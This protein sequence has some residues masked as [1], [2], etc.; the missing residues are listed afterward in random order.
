MQ[1]IL[2]LGFILILLYQTLS[3]TCRLKNT[4]YNLLT[5]VSGET[6]HLPLNE[7]FIGDALQYTITPKGQPFVQRRQQIGQ[8]VLQGTIISSTS[9]NFNNNPYIQ[10]IN[11]YAL[12][13]IS[14]LDFAIVQ[15]QLQSESYNIS[16]ASITSGTCYQVN[17]LQDMVVVTCS[18]SG[19]NI[20]EYQ[21]YQASNSSQ[22]FSILIDTIIIT[23]GSNLSVITQTAGQYI[24]TIVNQ[25]TFQNNS[26]SVISTNISAI[27]LLQEENGKYDFTQLQLPAI[28]ETNNNLVTDFYTGISLNQ[29]GMLFVSTYYNGFKPVNLLDL[30]V[31]INPFNPFNIGTMGVS[32][33]KIDISDDTF[34]LSIWSTE[35]LIVGVFQESVVNQKTGIFDNK[36]QFQQSQLILTSQITYGQIFT[37]QV[38]MNSRY[39]IVSNSNGISV[40]PS[41]LNTINDWKVLFYYNLNV[42]S[43]AFDYFNSILIAVADQ[44]VYTYEFNNPMITATNLPF[45][46]TTIQNITITATTNMYTNKNQKSCPPLQLFYNIT[47]N[48]YYLQIFNGYQVNSTKETYVQWGPLF[49]LNMGSIQTLNINKMLIGP[50]ILAGYPTTKQ[51]YSNFDIQFSNV[52]QTPSIQSPFKINS[53]IIGGQKILYSQIFYDNSF[54]ENYQDKVGD[55][56]NYL[57]LVQVSN[58]VA[59]FQCQALKDQPCTLIASIPVKDTLVEQFALSMSTNN[60]LN[61]AYMWNDFDINYKTYVGH[62]TICMLSFPYTAL[63]QTCKTIDY[64]SKQVNSSKGIQIAL[65][66]DNFYMLYQQT[67][68]GQQTQNYFSAINLL[69]FL[70]QNISIYELSSFLTY[71]N[72]NNVKINSFTYNVPAYGNIIFLNIEDSVVTDMIDYQYYVTAINYNGGYLNYS[73]KYSYKLEVIGTVQTYNSITKTDVQLQLTMEGIYILIINNPGQSTLTFYPRIDFMPLILFSKY[74]QTPPNLPV[75]G[76]QLQLYGIQKIVQSAASA[77][78][79]Y[80]MA[81]PINQNI[82][83][84]YV[85]KNTPSI[86]NAL[87]F[88]IET[89]ANDPIVNAPFSVTSAIYYDGIIF[90]SKG[91]D[92][93]RNSLLLKEFEF[94]VQCNLNSNFYEQ[95]EYSYVIFKASSQLYSSKL[96]DSAQEYQATFQSVN[97]ISFVKETSTIQNSTSIQ[98]SGYVQVDPRSYFLGN[99]QSFQLSNGTNQSSFYYFDIISPVER[100]PQTT[101]FQFPVTAVSAYMYIQT[102]QSQLSESNSQNQYWFTFVQTNR[103]VY[104][105]PYIYYNPPQDFVNNST[106]K[107]NYPLIYKLPILDISP[108]SQKCPLIFVDKYSL[109]VVSVCGTNINNKFAASFTLFNTLTQKVQETKI[110]ILNEAFPTLGQLN[111]TNNGS[112]SLQSA[113]Y[114]D[115]GVVVLQ[116]Q[117]N[118]NFGSSPPTIIILPFLYT[119]N[120]DTKIAI[121]P[122]NPNVSY[123]Q[124][125]QPI[126]QIYQVPN[127]TLANQYSVTVFSITTEYF[128]GLNNPQISNPLPQIKFGYICV[129]EIDE[130][131]LQSYPQANNT[132]GSASGFVITLI[133]DANLS[134]IFQT[135]ANVSYNQTNIMI[136]TSSK[137]FLLALMHLVSSYT[138][139]SIQQVI[140]AGSPIIEFNTISLV[141]LIAVS[142]GTAYIFKLQFQLSNGQYLQSQYACT[143]LGLSDKN[144]ILQISASSSNTNQ[145]QVVAIVSNPSNSSNNQVSLLNYGFINQQCNLQ[146]NAIKT[147]E[148]IIIKEEL[149]IIVTAIGSTT[150]VS[151]ETPP[152]LQLM[153]PPQIDNQTVADIARTLISDNQVITLLDTCPYLTI[154]AY[155]NYNIQGGVTLNSSVLFTQDSQQLITSISAM[156]IQ[157]YINNQLVSGK[158][159]STILNFNITQIPINQTFPNSVWDRKLWGQFIWGFFMFVIII[160]VLGY[161]FYKSQPLPYDRF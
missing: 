101:N 42:Q 58:Y 87:Y 52:L 96:P 139:N 116:F 102:E 71:E 145:Y 75:N 2:K 155:P 148:P 129:S 55:S 94:Q 82:Y 125:I 26:Y 86:Q 31:K 23:P 66:Q 130:S 77:R 110:I 7:Y 134:S 107:I 20:L 137:P 57:Q 159:G 142:Q 131:C 88:V 36:I 85:Y 122:Q 70:T 63:Y 153:Q 24:V 6:F 37:T 156:S 60:S 104:V 152:I 35:G 147:P 29:N 10:G 150:Y 146:P 50:A 121:Y 30:S 98:P 43:T 97:L 91:N 76:I 11:Y 64:N 21:F 81:Q 62:T 48:E 44:N 5:I 100:Q 72:I 103:L 93:Y 120:L 80:I 53:N 83:Q 106:V 138:Q 158:G 39:I 59:L 126:Q 3:Q 67:Q 132:Y 13:Q 22:N 124:Y 12:I 65:I 160:G 1:F 136:S 128:G 49:N 27:Q 4:E 109:G 144:P 119:A 135:N 90:K 68:D 28:L 161:L 15:S 105:T 123:Y 99:T 14:D 127:N 74:Q 38:F 79:L 117:Y 34:Y 45:L 108:N 9:S 84:I 33:Y 47:S 114:L 51:A 154:S 157:T 40:Y 16:F 18:S 92:G 25:G 78:F 143:L 141:P 56:D 112:Y 111:Y 61:I 140:Q 17:F 151:T 32:S 54:I 113:T 46:N 133:P 19:K 8:G 118:Y 41:I 69:E 73:T 149:E 95:T 89:D 115:I